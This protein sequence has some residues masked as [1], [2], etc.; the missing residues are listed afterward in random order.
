MALNPRI[1]RWAGL[2]VWVIGAS[3]GI[4]QALAERLAGQGARVAVSARSAAPLEAMAARSPGVRGWPLDATDAA[5]LQRAAG[6]IVQAFGGLDLMVYCA[7]YYRPMRASDF[8]LADALKHDDVNY[9]GALAAVAAVLPVL[10]AQG[11]GALAFVSSVAGFRGLPKS[12]AYG[13]TKAALINLAETLYIDLHDAGIGVHLINPGFVETPLTAGNE[14]KM[15]AL[16]TPAEAAQHI[17]DGLA[18]GAF[19]IHFPKRFTRWLKLMRLLPYRA[20]FA[21]V[22]RFTGL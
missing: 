8:D 14:F 6:D 2:R 18:A 16:I 12:L 13:P 9:R 7:G 11:H 10:R 20:Y 22:R 1:T 3:T 4:G 5:Q 15:P 17:C 19:E 21:V